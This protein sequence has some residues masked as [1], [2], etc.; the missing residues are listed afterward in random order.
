MLPLPATARSGKTLAFLGPAIVH[1]NAQP[2]L[3]RGDGPIV[4]RLASIG[5]PGLRLVRTE[6]CALD[7]YRTGVVAVSAVRSVSSCYRSSLLTHASASEAERFTV[8]DPS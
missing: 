2:Y 7:A 1:I 4:R 6:C 5:G 3:Q 8:E